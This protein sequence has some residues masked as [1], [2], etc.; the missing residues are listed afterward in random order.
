MK[1]FALKLFLFA[2]AFLIYDKIFILVANRSANA[3]VDKR[4]EFLI[5]GE[6]NKDLII[7]GS[8][9]GSRDIIA[10]QIEDKTGL[11]AYNLCYPGSNVDFH[12]FILETLVEFNKPP[13]YVLLVIDEDAEFLF[14]NTILFRKDRL[15]PLVKY[16]YIWKKLAE[17]D[18]KDRFFSKLLVLNRLNKYN[19]DLRKKRFTPL[20]TIMN[21]GSMPI[22]WQREGRKW[23]YVLS[24]KKYTTDNEE[25]AKLI[26]Y[27]KMVKLIKT[28]NIQLVVIFPPNYQT[29]SKL[30]ENRIRQLSGDGIYYC[31]YN[32]NN[33]IYQNKDYYY[34]ESHLMR[35]GAK[36][37]TDE[38]VIFLKDVMGTNAYNYH[39]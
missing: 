36:I 6:I 11:T 33:P 1:E 38:V 27:K 12:E 5:K 2:V 34:D 13:K 32:A 30:F 22:S 23:D 35:K 21:C 10:K 3:E 4:L 7:A 24:E 18:G 20:D 25:I 31:S 37:F 17:M 26:A 28:Y 19:F 14:D 9:R 39:P 29:H 15:Y 16:S 8:S